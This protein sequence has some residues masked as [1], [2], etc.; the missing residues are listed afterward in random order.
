MASGST[1]NRPIHDGFLAA[2]RVLRD[3]GRLT[4]ETAVLR[5]AS[6][7]CETPEAFEALLKSAERVHDKATA[8]A[9]FEKLETLY[10]AQR[11]KEQLAALRKHRLRFLQ[12]DG[13]DKPRVAGIMD[14]FTMA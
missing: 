14:E 6:D 5:A 1:E 11:D 12:R 13:V 2:A 3:M 8:A 10:E 4:S 9:A 7:R